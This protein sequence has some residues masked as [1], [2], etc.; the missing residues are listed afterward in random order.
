MRLGRNLRDGGAL[1][2]LVEVVVSDGAEAPHARGLVEIFVDSHDVVAVRFEL[3]PAERDPSIRRANVPSPYVLFAHDRKEIAPALGV[4]YPLPGTRV[5]LLTPD[6][7]ILLMPRNSTPEPRFVNLGRS[8]TSVPREDGRGH[9]T[10]RPFKECTSPTTTHSDGVYVVTGEYFARFYSD[11]GGAQSQLCPFPRPE[12]FGVE[13]FPCFGEDGRV[14]VEAGSGLAAHM[15]GAMVKARMGKVR[16]EGIV[17]RPTKDGP[18]KVVDRED[19]SQDLI[20][21]TADER[22]AYSEDREE[23]TRG[24]LE[25]LES[26][27]VETFGDFQAVSDEDLMKAMPVLK[28]PAVSQFRENVRAFFDARTREVTPEG[29]SAQ[30]QRPTK[31]KVRSGRKVRSSGR[32]KTTSRKKKKTSRRTS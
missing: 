28:P 15:S 12:D 23:R 25:V 19:G 2:R 24:A 8:D 27:G 5:K 16:L 22:L 18:K 32:K 17:I 26:L 13:E 1:L 6:K 31:K 4:V 9:I 7:E 20:D 11:V 3:F 29:E 14:D 21:L 10:V 30:T